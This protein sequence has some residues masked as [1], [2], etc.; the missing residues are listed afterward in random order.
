MAAFSSTSFDT[1]AFSVLAFD[2]GDTPA[3]PPAA[4]GVRPSGG[5]P[6]YDSG[7]TKKQTRRSRIVH[8]IINEVAERQAKALDLDAIQKRQEL[9]EE[10][11]LRGIEAE[12][13]YYEELSR[14]RERLI[15]EEIALRIRTMMEEEAI[16]FVLLCG[17]VVDA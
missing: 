13:S 6:A 12:I 9:T 16:A 8:G 11:R 7:P 2:F 1:S 14:V 3:P 5:F 17:T 4:T 10:L 15:S